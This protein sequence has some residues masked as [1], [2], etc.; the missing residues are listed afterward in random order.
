MNQVQTFCENGELTNLFLRVKV[1]DI[2]K[3]TNVQM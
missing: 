3:F 2:S 1:V